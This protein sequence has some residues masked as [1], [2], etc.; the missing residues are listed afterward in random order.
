MRILQIQYPEG[1]SAQGYRDAQLGN[2]FLGD[3]LEVLG[4][5]RAV[6]A[7]GHHDAFAAFEGEAK[8]TVLETLSIV[9]R[10]GAATFRP[11]FLREQAE[12]TAQRVDLEDRY[13]LEFVEVGEVVNDNPRQVLAISPPKS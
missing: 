1:P 13:V 6:V 8:Q 4:F 5:D 2:D 11:A 9:G 10:D 3:L 12:V 7:I